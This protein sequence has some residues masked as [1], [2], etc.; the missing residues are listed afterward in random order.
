MLSLMPILDSILK[1]FMHFNTNLCWITF[2]ALL[3]ILDSRIAFTL[4]TSINSKNSNERSYV[5]FYHGFLYSRFK[6]QF[7]LFTV[8]SLGAGVFLSK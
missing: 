8:S 6:H 7:L 1:S 2:H 5:D 3:N 4:E